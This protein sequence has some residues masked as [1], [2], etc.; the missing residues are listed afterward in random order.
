MSSMIFLIMVLV[1]GCVTLLVVS[2]K[3]LFK[4]KVNINRFAPNW[5]EEKEHYEVYENKKRK[6]ISPVLIFFIIVSSS[7]G[8][9]VIYL[10]T[11][12]LKF[13]LLGML[14]GFLIPSIWTNYYHKRNRK[15]IYIQLEQTAE[16]MASVL[17]SGSGIVDAL[18]RAANEIQNPLREELLTTANE[19]KLGISTAIAFQNLA[20]RL[21]V[22]EMK[23]LSMGINLQQGGMAVNLGALLNQIQENIR[24]KLAF[25]REVNV[26][27]AENK[28]AGW[29]VSVLPFV[30]LAIMR[31]I[32]PDIV[33]PL[34]TTTIGLIIFGFNVV[35][36]VVG[37]VWLMKIASIQV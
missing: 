34:F 7:I 16:I 12:L 36:I 23:I 13:S 28:L 30:T 19:V 9:G 3:T 26:I 11:G 22:D 25:Q 27:T 33:A 31:A 24:Y 32:M 1:F 21:N 6:K 29:I 18:T 10:V 14:V 35:V 37:I 17:R 15:L 4:R 5:E 8:F 2:L 20:I